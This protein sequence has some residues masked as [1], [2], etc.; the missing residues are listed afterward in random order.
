MWNKITS[1]LLALSLMLTPVLAMA[2]SPVPTG[3]KITGLRYQQK[4]PYSGVL[5]NSI[6]AAKLLT[7]KNYSEEQWKLKL[8]YELAK[9]SAEL[10]L[11]I[12]SQKASHQALEQKHLTLIKIKDSEIE[13]LSKIASNKK[14]Y[15]VWWAT[16]GV[17][18]G[19]GLTIAVVYA[20]QPGLK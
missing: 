4:A 14:N 15:S 16:G 9:Q 18:V 1:I 12:E 5:L 19:I 17:V 10:N 8:Q 13:R 7:D 6:A 11:I 3:G 20:V 2:Q